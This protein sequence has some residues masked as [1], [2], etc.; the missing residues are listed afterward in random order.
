MVLLARLAS[1]ACLAHPGTAIQ[2]ADRRTHLLAWA[3]F[4]AAS[5]ACQSQSSLKLGLRVMGPSRRPHGVLAR[6]PSGLHGRSSGR[7]SALP[8]VRE[9][10]KGRSLR[11]TP[12]WLPPPSRD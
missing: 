10:G 1:P 9:T 2:A 4:G 3:H 12:P 5:T 11:S 6:P 7:L 8:A